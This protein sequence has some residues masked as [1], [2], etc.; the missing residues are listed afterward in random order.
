M[1]AAVRGTCVQLEVLW[2]QIL[3]SIVENLV[4]RLR[5][6]WMQFSSRIPF[7]GRSVIPPSENA[8]AT[9]I[10]P[11]ITEVVTIARKG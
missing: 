10:C 9:G 4:H 2:V 3:Q 6:T 7:S 5:A 1:G 11:P 8:A